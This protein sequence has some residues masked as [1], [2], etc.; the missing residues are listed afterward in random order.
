MAEQ[1][2]KDCGRQASEALEAIVKA[3]EGLSR[4]AQVRVLKA[5]ACFYDI[6]LEFD[7]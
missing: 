3:L 6:C 2:Q 5:A 1:K 7:E 4:D